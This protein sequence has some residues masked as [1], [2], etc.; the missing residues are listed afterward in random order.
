MEPGSIQHSGYLTPGDEINVQGGFTVHF[1]VNIYF[2][3]I[4]IDMMH[5]FLNLKTRN[6]WIKFA[7]QRRHTNPGQQRIA[8]RRAGHPNNILYKM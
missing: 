8:G 6:A 2:L 7:R 1:Q 4:I 3:M 5:T